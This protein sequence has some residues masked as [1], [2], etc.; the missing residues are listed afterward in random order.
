MGTQEVQQKGCLLFLSGR[1]DLHNAPA[2]ESLSLDSPVDSGSPP[3]ILLPGAAALHHGPPVHQ[4]S[5]DS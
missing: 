5:L 2:L 4:P 1:W 3:T